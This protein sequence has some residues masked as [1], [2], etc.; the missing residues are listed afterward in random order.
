MNSG[1]YCEFYKD[2]FF[3]YGEKGDF[4]YGS[5]WHIL[6]ILLLLVGIYLTYRYRER[7]K[8]WKHEESFR[9]VLAFSIMIIE[10]SY[11]WRLLYVGSSHLDEFNLMDK[12]PLQVCQWSAIFSVFMLCK[13]SRGFYDLCFYMCCT[14]GLV[15]LITPAVISTTGPRY[16]RYYQFWLE[17]LLP[18][19]AV[20]Y[21][22]M[23]HGCV[24]TR[25]RMYKAILFIALLGVFAIPA[26][27]AY[28]NANYLYLASNTAGASAANFLPANMWLRAGVYAC[29]MVVVFFL[30]SLL[31]P[32]IKRK[33]APEPA[34]AEKA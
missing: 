11:Y 21:M 28:D 34:T 2:G 17:H 22:T 26:N 31:L 6:P 4:Q 27:L 32:L 23:V 30:V 13:K 3:G 33:F 20:W 29:A 9:Y 18:L 19:Y 12:L 8:S 10:M 1:V 16:Y 25:K 7:L 24:T 15:P 5:V 14:F